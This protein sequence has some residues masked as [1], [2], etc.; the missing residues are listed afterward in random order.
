MVFSESVTEMMPSIL[1]S[2]QKKEMSESENVFLSNS[3]RLGTL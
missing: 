2:P 3:Q 1:I